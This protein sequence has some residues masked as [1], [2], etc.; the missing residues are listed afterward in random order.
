MRFAVFLALIAACDEH[1][2]RPDDFIP[3]GGDDPPPI[4]APE[5]PCEL[6]GRTMQPGVTWRDECNTCMCRGGVAQCTLLG[7]PPANGDESA[8]CAPSGACPDGPQCG[9]SCCGSG[10]HCNGWFCVCGND[11]QVCGPAAFCFDDGACN[12]FCSIPL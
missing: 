10:E 11:D 4:D 9:T 12:S 6:E 5:G 7:C 1:G 8:S 2:R 3:D